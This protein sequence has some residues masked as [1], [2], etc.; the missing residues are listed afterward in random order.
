MSLAGIA[1][2]SAKPGVMAL[3]LVVAVE[4]AAQAY[5]PASLDRVEQARPH[6]PGL[7]PSAVRAMDQEHEMDLQALDA[8]EG[9]RRADLFRPL[10]RPGP[11][12]LYGRFGL[13]NFQY[14]LDPD[15]SGMQ[16]TWR[17]TGPGLAGKI[18]VGIHRRF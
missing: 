18:Y 5:R 15:S 7:S 4:A 14:Q 8:F 3:L 12:K 9:K 16:F 17:R 1:M 13:V 10:E 6:L 2:R 11:W